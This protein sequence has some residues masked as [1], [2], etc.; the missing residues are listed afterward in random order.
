MEEIIFI[1]IDDDELVINSLSKLIGKVFPHNQIKSEVN[2]I[3]AWDI[4]KA[5][6][7]PMIIISDLTM[8]GLNG[9]QVLKKVR[10]V[11]TPIPSYFILL[12][13][14]LDKD[15]NLKALQQGA[16]DFINKPFSVDDLIGKL[17]S[18]HRILSLQIK[19]L[20]EK[21]NIAALKTEIS[22]YRTR[23][24][25]MM[26]TVQQIKFPEMEKNA[27]RY[28]DMAQ[29]IALEYGDVGGEEIEN[30][31][32]AAS[33]CYV[34]RLNLPET[35]LKGSLLTDGLPKN[36]TIL[37][38]PDFIKSF[39]AS[40]RDFDEV[41]KILVHVYEN[42]DGSGFPDKLK[43]WQIPLGARIIR[44]I[45]DF[46]EQ[47]VLKKVNQSKAIEALEHENR[48]LYDFK[49]VAL[50]DQYFAAH[51]NKEKPI[52]AKDIA[53]GMM[54][55]RNI[56]TTS[57]M[58]IMGAGNAMTIEKIE[59]LHSIVNTDPVIGRIYIRI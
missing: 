35:V 52:R 1:V 33:L 9:L 16:D 34:G 6:T 44:T 37:T 48:R 56:I 24:I 10:A 58:K 51:G 57:G 4:I 19:Q 49:L 12:T 11:E 38:M 30:I 28:R 45:L 13:A 36:E 32:I 59:K 25:N 41:I 50:L 54:I 15:A 5:E 40:V 53:E 31:T 27:P 42:F 2:G 29:W 46:D 20:E 8:P 18:A 47:I 21:N 14:N 3:D 22:E 7:K 39:L 26:Q 55:T 23:M 17:R 43:S